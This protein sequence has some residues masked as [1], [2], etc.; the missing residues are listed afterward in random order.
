MSHGKDSR[1]GIGGVAGFSKGDGGID[2]AAG[3]ASASVT[4]LTLDPLH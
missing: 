1:S 2:E 4:N 3:N